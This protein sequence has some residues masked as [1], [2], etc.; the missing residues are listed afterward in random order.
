[1]LLASLRCWTVWILP[2][3]YAELIIDAAAIPVASAAQSVRSRIQL[4]R[5]TH[6]GCS[7]VA[8]WFLHRMRRG[9]KRKR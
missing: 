6:I 3:L 9:S 4:S 7:R 1:M 5:W 2:F 8:I